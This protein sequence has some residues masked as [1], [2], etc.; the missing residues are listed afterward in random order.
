MAYL[1]KHGSR[2][3][4]SGNREEALATAMKVSQLFVGIIHVEGGDGRIVR[5]YVYGKS[6]PSME[7][8]RHALVYLKYCTEV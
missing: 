4:A 5:R 1:V 2:L 6:M 3:I 8:A 7:K